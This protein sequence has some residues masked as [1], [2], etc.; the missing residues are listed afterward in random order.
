M[1]CTSLFSRDFL[2]AALEW[3]IELVEEYI[4]LDFLTKGN[5]DSW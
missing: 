3:D 1:H 4:D 2:S 5:G